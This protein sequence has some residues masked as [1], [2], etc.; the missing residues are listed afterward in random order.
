M[1]IYV[2]NVCEYKKRKEH[3]FIYE[4]FLPLHNILILSLL[5]SLYTAYIFVNTVEPRYKDVIDVLMHL[6][7]LLQCALCLLK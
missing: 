6:K 4:P 7:L 1:C 3:V 5:D 2:K